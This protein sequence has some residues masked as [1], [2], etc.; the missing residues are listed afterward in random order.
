LVADAGF[1][2]WLGNTRGNRYSKKHV[3]LNATSKEFWDFSFQE[4]ADYDLPSMIDF[5]LSKTNQSELNYL[6]YSQGNTI[7]FAALSEQKELQKKIKLNIAL[8]PMT[9]MKHVNNLL[10]SLCSYDVQLKSLIELFDVREFFQTSEAWNIV[11]D[12]ACTNVPQICDI[13][14]GIMAGM[15]LTKNYNA[16]RFPLYATYI[17]AGTSTKNLVHYMQL[18]NS[19]VFRRYDNRPHESYWSAGGVPEMYDITK[20]PNPTVLIGSDGDITSTT[21]DVNWLQKQLQH[22]TSR[23]E[24]REFNHLE[25]VWAPAMKPIYEKIIRM[26]Q[27]Y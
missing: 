13:L 22:V 27:K 21:K 12:V 6:G 16:T 2:V 17:P 5:V 10:T 23:I 14:Y 25:L 20:I 24:L 4:M 1:D 11:S 18:I 9:R 7:A 26:A 19:H 3:S 15:D 8:G